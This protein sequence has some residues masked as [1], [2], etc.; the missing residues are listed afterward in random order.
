VL[1]CAKLLD[2][3]SALQSVHSM[4]VSLARETVRLLAMHSAFLS[5]RW[6]AWL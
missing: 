4:A 5:V 2:E 6:M 3:Q 1:L